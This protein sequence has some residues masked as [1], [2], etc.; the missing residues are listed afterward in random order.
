MIL[1]LGTGSQVWEQTCLG[2]TAPKCIRDPIDS[3]VA[4]LQEFLWRYSP[5]PKIS[6]KLKKWDYCVLKTVTWT[7]KVK[8][9]MSGTGDKCFLLDEPSEHCYLP[10]STER[11]LS[12]TGVALLSRVS[13]VRTSTSVSVH[14]SPEPTL[15]PSIF[16]CLPFLNLRP[17]KG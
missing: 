2:T 4:F 14:L 5:T 8:D 15:L 16:H 13:S 10:C 12:Y 1:I 7:V 6:S 17:S 11:K 3:P 9:C